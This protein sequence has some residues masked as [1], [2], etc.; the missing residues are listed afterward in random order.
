MKSRIDK[1]VT[2]VSSAGADA[3]F[4][5]NTPD[6]EWICGFEHTFDEERAHALFIEVIG[7][8]PV[9]K[10]HTDSRYSLACS[11]EAARLGG[12]IEVCSDRVSHAKW[13]YDLMQQS[14]TKLACED[15][16]T[17]REFEALKLAFAVQDKVF[18]KSETKQIASPFLITKDMCLNLRAVKDSDEI[19]KMQ[20]AQAITDA[21]F[22]WI[23][24]FIKPGKTELEIARALD[25]KM[26]E[27]G[28]DALAFP[29]IVACGANG[30]SPHAQ[31]GSRVLE[32]GQCVVMDFGAK[33]NGYCSDMTRTVFIGEPRGRMMRAWN[34]LRNANAQVRAMLKPGVTGIEAHSLA[35]QILADAGFGG[36][37]GHGLGHGVGLEIHEE[38]CLNLRNDMPL[39]PGNVV[40][41]EPGIYIEGEFGMRLE[42]FGVITESGFETFTKST[43][44]T[45]VL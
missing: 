22:E 44:E 39:V 7:D 4:I 34:A 40:T 33:K 23:C 41:V 27:L 8:T 1:L 9:V 19:A 16:L 5:R 11:R 15:T 37:M 32:H 3:A 6:I 13:V 14:S 30:A 28:A 42:D 26:F 17:L 25:N 18:D 43:H 29:T 35:E 20:S 31:P 38:P 24:D 45:V 21:V 36:C 2:A 12:V 10:L